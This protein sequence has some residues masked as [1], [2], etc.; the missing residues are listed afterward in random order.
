METLLFWTLPV[1]TALLGLK[2]RLIAGWR[3]FFASAAA[4]Y[5]GFW[6][7]PKWW[8]LLDFLPPEAEPYRN[9]AAIAVGALAI[10][11]ALYFGAKAITQCEDDAFNFPT[12]PERALNALCRF[13]FGVC[14]STFLMLLC[15][16]TPLRMLTRNDGAGF[17]AR[18]EEAR[19]AVTRVGDALTRTRPSQL[20]EEALTSFRYVP[21][22]PPEEEENDKAQK[23][24]K[25]A[26][27]AGGK[28]DKA[29]KPEKG[30][31]PAGGKKDKAAPPTGKAG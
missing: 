4:L 11:S 25:G 17:E 2:G 27:P 13:G 7:A 1:L 10:F 18:A 29:Q 20:R 15:E 22:E 9:G 3:L 28:K 12:I 5:A 31:V 21:P 30:A 24:E 23:P 19:L 8:S 6:L 14:L 26:A 16:V